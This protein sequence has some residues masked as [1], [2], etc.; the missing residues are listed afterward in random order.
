MIQSGMIT[1]TTVKATGPPG[2]NVRPAERFGPWP[3][4]TGAYSPQWT[5]VATVSPGASITPKRAGR[6]RLVDVG[7]ADAGCAYGELQDQNGGTPVSLR[8]Q[9]LHQFG[10]H[11]I[12]TR[13][14]PLPRVAISSEAPGSPILATEITPKMA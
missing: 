10:T 4:P 14:A 13:L 12:P 6:C 3:S 1:P 2:S 9:T 5:H 11:G 8:C 7:P